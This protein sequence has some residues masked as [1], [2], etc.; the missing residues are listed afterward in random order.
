MILT[1]AR[2][3]PDAGKTVIEKVI[4]LSLRAVCLEGDKPTLKKNCEG[5]DRKENW[6]QGGWGVGLRR[7]LSKLGALSRDLKNAS[8]IWVK[9][10]GRSSCLGKLQGEIP[11]VCQR[12]A[13]LGHT[14]R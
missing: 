6:S 7:V 1:C 12:R 4:T 2:N 10:Q 9:D 14:V 13:R 3:V 8:R 5:A 11:K